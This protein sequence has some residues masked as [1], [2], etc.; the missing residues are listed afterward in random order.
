VYMGI[1]VP[2][3]F[4]RP[5]GPADLTD[6]ERARS[7]ML[8]DDFYGTWPRDLRCF[9]EDAE[10]PWRAWPWRR[11]D[12]E[13][14]DFA[15]QGEQDTISK[16]WKRVPGVTLLGDAAHASTPNGEGANE[17]MY[18]AMML[19]ERIEEETGGSSATNVAAAG[20]D[21]E[22]DGAAMERAVDAYEAEMR[23]R[24][25]EFIKRCMMMEDMMFSGGII[26]KFKKLK[27]QQAQ[28]QKQ[29]E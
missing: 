2:E 21:E 29:T 3:D 24:A 28:K 4:T 14:Y 6:L 22:A 11:M 8:S 1:Q 16:R 13:M 26:E 20:Y 17:A 27:M 25:A 18:D 15:P 7:V 10:G 19:F 23:P 9:V 5:G 12:P